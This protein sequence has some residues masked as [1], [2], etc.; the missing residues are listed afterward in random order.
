MP[1]GERVLFSG[2]MAGGASALSA[3]SGGNSLST[4]LSSGFP[5]ASGLASGL[6]LASFW[7]VFLSA[8]LPS[9]DLPS[10]DFPSAYLPSADLPSADLASPDLASV[11]LSTAGSR[12]GMRSLRPSITTIASGF[13]VARMPFAAATQSD[14]SPLG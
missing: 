12:I 1:L 3:S 4:A 11:D 6:A 2:L 7:S 9:A 14:G 8:V 13:S 10:A 5:A